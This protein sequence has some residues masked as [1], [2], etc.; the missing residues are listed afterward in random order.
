MTT[1]ESLISI[2]V[3]IYNAE[4]QIHRLLDSLL[5][6]TWN[7]FEVLLIDDGSTDRSGII[8]EEYTDRDPR[9]KVIHKQNGGVG[10]ARQV[11]L[12]AAIGEFVI[13]ADADDWI[14]SSMLYDMLQKAEHSQADVVILCG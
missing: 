10:T 2:I 8:C 12:D 14:E 9:F 3:P 7:H 6:Q 4:H 11:G 1:N 13:H 5:L